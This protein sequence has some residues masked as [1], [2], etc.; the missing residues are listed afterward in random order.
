MK[1]SV[2]PVVL[3]T[4]AVL[5][6]CAP[7]HAAPSVAKSRVAQQRCFAYPKDQVLRGYFQPGEEQEMFRW[8]TRCTS[9]TSTSVTGNGWLAGTL[10]RLENG[11]WQSLAKGQYLYAM[12]SPGT[13]RVVVKNES[14]ARAYYTIRHGHA[15]GR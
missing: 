5:V 11:R 2:K 4:F 15:I 8:T 10:E 7:L 3:G 1:N 6:S 12:A 9:P 14:Q 13:Y